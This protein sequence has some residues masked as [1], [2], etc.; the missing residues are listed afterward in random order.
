MTLTIL[1]GSRGSGGERQQQ[2]EFGLQQ[3]YSRR[4][5]RD[6]GRDFRSPRASSAPIASVFLLG[7]VDP[8]Q[9]RCA[10]QSQLVRTDRSQGRFRY[11]LQGGTPFTWTFVSCRLNP[12]AGGRDFGRFSSPPWSER[13]APIEVTSTAGGKPDWRPLQRDEH[14]RRADAHGHTHHDLDGT[15]YA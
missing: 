11:G 14:G 10:C 5:R 12:T 4:R 7:A 13:W 6:G 15:V 1:F 2:A 8:L 9:P 3:R